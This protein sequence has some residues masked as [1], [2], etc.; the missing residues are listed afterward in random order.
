MEKLDDGAIAAEMLAAELEGLRH[1]AAG[2]CAL[3][4]VQGLKPRQLAGG[5]YSLENCDR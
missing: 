3:A 2:L 5:K 1:P 4:R